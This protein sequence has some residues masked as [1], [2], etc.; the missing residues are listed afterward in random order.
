MTSSGKGVLSRLEMR[1]SRSPRCQ[2]LAAHR[3]GEPPTD[4]GVTL[5]ITYALVQQHWSIA[6]LSVAP[7]VSTWARMI[8]SPGSENVA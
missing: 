3:R 1:L 5:T 2:E 8:Y 7:K 4:Y 6:V